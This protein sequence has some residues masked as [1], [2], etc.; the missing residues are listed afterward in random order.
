MSLINITYFNPNESFLV[1][2]GKSD[3]ER[4]TYWH[5]N[6]TENCEAYK[7]G[8]CVMFDGIFSVGRCPYGTKEKKIGFTKA[9]RACGQLSREAKAKYPDLCYVLNRVNNFYR[10]GDYIF[11]PIGY[12]YK[13]RFREWNSDFWGGENLVHI[14]YYTPEILKE[15]CEFRP[16]AWL[17]D[18][19]ITTYQT[20]EIPMFL[21]KLKKYDEDMYNRL[22][23][24]YPDAETKLSSLSFVGKDAKLSTLKHGKVKVGTHVCDW[25]GEK[26]TYSRNPTIGGVNGTYYCIPD[27]DAYVEVLHNDTVTEETIFKE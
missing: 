7:A 8:R 23:E 3:R 5:C 25:D 14:K 4:V 20:K 11:F 12:I 26:L 27:N 13:A 2:A 10:I 24:I 19:E 21:Y 1:K 17:S 22:V 15:I 16:R 18:K 9:A 6:N